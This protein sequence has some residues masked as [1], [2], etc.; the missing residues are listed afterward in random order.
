MS[1]RRRFLCSARSDAD[2][3][4]MH[5]ILHRLAEIA[6]DDRLCYHDDRLS[7]RDAYYLFHGVDFV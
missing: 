1:T 4:A 5:V 6:P 3:D 7:Y 2:N